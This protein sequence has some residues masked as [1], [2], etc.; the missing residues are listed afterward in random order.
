MKE[1]EGG[2]EFFE[3]TVRVKGTEVLYGGRVNQLRAGASVMRKFLHLWTGTLK[4]IRTKV[5][6]MKG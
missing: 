6:R 2:E 4:L 3:D 5:F 1:Y